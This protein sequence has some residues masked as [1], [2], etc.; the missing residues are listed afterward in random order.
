MVTGCAQATTRGMGHAD[1]RAPFAALA[2][3]AALAAVPFALAL[4]VHPPDSG[5]AA[6]PA[7]L[8]DQP[9]SL[10]SLLACGTPAGN[11]ALL[12]ATFAPFR[13]AVRFCWDANHFYEES[14]SMPDPVQMPNVMAGITSWQQQVP[15][16]TSYFQAVT[17]PE[18]N[19]GSLG[20]GQPNV[21]RIPLVPVPAASPIP[22]SGGNF[23]RG[24][25]ALAVNGIPI[26][27]PRN[28]TGQFSYAIGE[29]DTYGG[30]C[31]RANDYHYHVAPLH[32]QPLVGAGKPVAWAL[33]G[34]PIY[35]YDEPDGTPRQA[36]DADGGHTVAPW[37]YHYHA[38]GS[39]A[40]G[41]QSP[42]LMNAF[43]GTVV[44]FG[45][46]VDPQPDA[47][48]YEPAFTALQGARIVSSTRPSADSFALTY[49]VNS[50]SYVVS[51]TLDRKT[52]TITMHREAPSGTTNVAYTSTKR[53]QS[54][55]PAPRSM[56][57]LPDTGQAASATATFGEDADYLINAPAFT[58]NGD[59][60]VTDAVTGL[61]WQKV[62]SGEMTWESAMAGA[63]ALTLGGYTD[64]RLPTP[65]EA[66][67]ILDHGRN[68]ALNPAYFQDNASGTSQYWWTTDP[69]GTDLTRV[70]ATNSGG[71]M[72]PHS[73]TQ[74]VSAGGTSRFCARYV[75]GAKAWNTHTYYNNGDGTVTDL[76]TGLMWTQ[77]PGSAMTWNAAI[78]WA[79]GLTT[80][81]YTDWRLPN[82]KEL[83]SIVDITQA[84]ATTAAA[85][86]APVN[87]LLFPG[88]TATAHWSSTPL[89]SPTLTSAWL[90]E[91]GVNTAVP[92]ANGPTRNLQGIVSYE[93][94]SS[95]YPAF[96]VRTAAPVSCDC[97]ADLN[98]DRRVDGIDLGRLL[99]AWG[100]ASASTGADINRDGIVDGQDLG[101]LLA[102]WGS[103]P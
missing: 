13:P 34:Y 101:A 72:G 64:W 9:S 33:D 90:V 81:G 87:R 93:V 36:L 3:L 1:R 61:M 28:N 4:P 76:D 38:I 6:V 46:Q 30:H 57:A 63:A 20:Y 82:V 89:R 66:F 5:D 26:F 77:A 80:G 29:L 17:N 58:D 79:E 53:F 88:T 62:D 37:G 75:R 70:W 100:A 59:G 51:W 15:V 18:T 45:G 27:N 60:T 65:M 92:P 47:I 7:A 24:A 23:Q 39:A 22:L 74:T 12:V 31:G 98:N 96:A 67:G 50:A 21:W 84:V 71:G 103:C 95:A 2:T 52:R 56:A 48:N 86:K 35:G 91:F 44:N 68:P 73:K 16:P 19:T 99:A 54:Y 97:P 102:A 78:A 10:A 42:Y 40:A 8:A 25:I 41:P 55:A 43:H 85:S 83:Q 69:F 49:T 32:L 11:G 14:D 94:Q